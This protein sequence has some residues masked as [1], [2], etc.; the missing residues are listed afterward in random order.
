MKHL[1]KL[2]S[3]LL[4]LVMVLALAVPAFAADDAVMV[5]VSSTNP[6]HQFE[7][8]QIFTA[9]Q[10][11][12]E[13]GKL[14]G[15]LDLNNIQWGEAVTNAETLWN[16]LEEK[17]PNVFRSSEDTIEG[18]AYPANRPTGLSTK[19]SDSAKAVAKLLMDNFARGTTDKTIPDNAELAKVFY[20]VFKAANARKTLVQT[21]TKVLTGYYLVTDSL[22]N[23][24]SIAEYMLWNITQ[25][26]P[27]TPKASTSKV[28]K[29]VFDPISGTYKDAAIYS[30]GEAGMT[31]A[32]G[33]VPTTGDKIQFKIT[34]D[35][36]T[37]LK[38]YTTENPYNLELRDKM[39]S[40]LTYAGIKSVKLYG[41]TDD[42]TDTDAGTEVAEQYYTEITN[43]SD[44]T[45]IFQVPSLQQIG[46]A[47]GKLVLIYEAT[48]NP[49]TVTG[50]AGNDN[51]V[52]LWVNENKLDEDDST[53]YSLEVIVNKVNAAGQPLEGARFALV[54]EADLDN[55]WD[56]NGN[57]LIDGA[58]E[59][60]L[61][62]L[63]AGT[64]AVHTVKNLKVGTYYL[65]ETQ[66]PDGGYNAIAP[67]KVTINA[68]V[69]DQTALK[70]TIEQEGKDFS[71]DESNMKVSADIENRTG[72]MLPETGGIGTT[73]FYIVGGLLVVGAVVLLITKRRTSADE[74]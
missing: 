28:K 36:P 48:F 58:D 45:F 63:T 13:N 69:D 43:N 46:Q 47:N 24:A 49:N 72:S 20:D 14:D 44:W 38:N 29:E 12:D 16:A 40:T 17:Y 53:V 54:A 6:T 32:A 66:V 56:S 70:V 22:D 5:D 31:D 51:T 52:E 61:I 73:I 3:V 19:T 7:T 57:K 60:K 30:E 1:K 34:V 18:T 59:S 11:K 71:V 50:S 9:P 25:A 74:E 37:N 10:N 33:N 27:I 65:V 39:S 35:L 62:P 15:S 68:T 42:A 64:G 55:V 23:G 26:T 8:Y 21:D 41:P 4:A 67:I 2:G